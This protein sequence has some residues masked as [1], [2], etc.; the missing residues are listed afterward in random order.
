MIVNT[1]G[2]KPKPLLT[3]I[4]L[5]LLLSSDQI[6]GYLLPIFVWCH[7]PWNMILSFTKQYFVE[8]QKGLVGILTIIMTYY[9]IPYRTGWFVIPLHLDR[10]FVCKILC[11]ITKKTLPILAEILHKNGRS[12]YNSTKRGEMITAHLAFFGIAGGDSTFSRS[13]SLSS[14][15]MASGT[16]GWTKHPL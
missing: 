8:C 1:T 9:K 7:K 6:F 16:G 15:A 12:R 4:S 10:P 13:P 3:W 14:F 5:I 11:L 2:S